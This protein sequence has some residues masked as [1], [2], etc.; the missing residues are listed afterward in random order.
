MRQIILFAI[1]VFAEFHAL[2]AQNP[3]GTNPPSASLQI[4]NGAS[5]HP[6]SLS[7]DG[8]ELY[9]SLKSGA[10]ISNFAVTKP[11]VLLKVQKNGAGDLKEFPLSLTAG[12][13]YTLC[14]LGDFAPLPPVKA[15]DGKMKQDFRIQA[16]L[17]EN[18]GS[19]GDQVVVRAV[20][21]LP[22]RP[23]VLARSNLNVLRVNAGQVGVSTKLPAELFLE[24]SD[25]KTKQNL[26]LAQKPP[27]ANITVIF[28]EQ[29]G[30]FSFKAMT[31]RM[32]ER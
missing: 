13:S 1:L 4:L 23:V 22:D 27:A 26:Y 8:K 17:L 14:L 15:Q 24:A 19:G 16:L 6:I 18:E 7:F 5:P 11:A 21:A 25:G 10:R 31:E 9:P 2:V 20:N 12:K 28:F 3:V 30:Q 32:L 29:E